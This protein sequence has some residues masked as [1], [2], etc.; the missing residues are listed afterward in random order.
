MYVVQEKARS[1]SKEIQVV[2]SALFK[3]NFK[4]VQPYQYKMA[5]ANVLKPCQTAINELLASV[6]HMVNTFGWFELSFCLFWLIYCLFN[7]F[8]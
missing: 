6:E 8:A 2:K 3:M 7:L 5:F 4:E 1:I